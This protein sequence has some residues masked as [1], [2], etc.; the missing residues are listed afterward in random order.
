MVLNTK[1][2]QIGLIRFWANL[3]HSQKNRFP[4]LVI[5][6]VSIE[7]DKVIINGFRWYQNQWKK[8]MK[9]LRSNL[10]C[11]IFSSFLLLYCFNIK[12]LMTIRNACYLKRQGFR[13]PSLCNK[14][15]QSSSIEVASVSIVINRNMWDN[16]CKFWQ[17]LLKSL[18]V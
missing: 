13:H 12:H 1:P 8:I 17:L 14:C 16:W 7:N 15:R 2:H 18:V 5:G 4:S 6:D 10:V 9:N 11:F 3:F